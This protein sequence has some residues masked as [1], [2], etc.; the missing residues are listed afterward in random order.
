MMQSTREVWQPLLRRLIVSCQAPEGSALRDPNVIA[1]MARETVAAG[2]AG[3]R[4]DGPENAAAIRQLVDVPIVGI[5]KVLHEDGRVLITPTYESARDLVAAGASMI[6]LDCTVRG[7]RFGAFG[8]I[9]AI[10]RNL[11]VPVLADVA[12]VE[13]AVA[14]A[15]AGADLVLTTLRGYTPETA[16]IRGFDLQFL[17]DIVREAGVPVIAEGR[18]A[19][20]SQ[21]RAA[22]DSGAFAIIV[23]TAITRPDEITRRFIAAME[24]SAAGDG[25]SAV[26]GIDLGGTNTKAALVMRDGRTVAE[27]SVPTPAAAGKVGLLEHLRTLAETC[28]AAAAREGLEVQTLGIATAGW[29]DPVEGCVV[30][31]TGN[32]PGWTGVSLRA[33]LESA[34]GLGVHVE[35]DAN[36][37][38]IGERCFGLAREVDN[39][40]CITL[41]TGVGGGC[42]IG[43]KLNRGANYLANA[44]GHINVEKDGRSCTC[45]QKGCLEAYA[46]AAALLSYAGPGFG[47]AEQVIRAANAG[48]PAAHEALRTYAGWLARGCAQMVHL[49]D[50]ELLV[51]SGGIAQDNPMLLLELEKQLSTQVIGWSRRNLRVAVSPLACFGGVIGAAAVAFASVEERRA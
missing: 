43:G 50:P 1:R 22:L 29:V 45:G 26:I 30:Y 32:L 38:A 12:T 27:T 48:N 14:A 41:G 49:L 4:A 2:A 36:A 46:N 8:R 31:A 17:R 37:L 44:L 47:T 25:A 11:G 21:A 9:D 3:I 42:Y 13:E 19:E 5:A 16:H 20:P 33:E 7:Q 15:A 35:N 6:A 23:G 34:T 10:K 24:E 40:V 28:K 18:I 51:V 39:F